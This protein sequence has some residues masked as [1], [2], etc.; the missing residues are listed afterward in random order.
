MA[1]ADYCLSSFCGALPWF[2]GLCI[3]HFNMRAGAQHNQSIGCRRCGAE[4]QAGS[5]TS[6]VC[7]DCKAVLSRE[8]LAVWRA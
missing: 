3:F 6:S 5:G 2:D 1:R 4:R 7:R 8:E